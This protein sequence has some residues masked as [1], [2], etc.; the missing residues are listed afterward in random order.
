MCIFSLIFIKNGYVSVTIRGILTDDIF[1]K[2]KDNETS[3]QILVGFA[4]FVLSFIDIS[5]Y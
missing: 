3:L 4:G 1:L 2:F 5:Y